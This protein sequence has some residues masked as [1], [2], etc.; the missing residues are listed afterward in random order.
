MSSFGSK[1]RRGEGGRIAF[2]C[3][4]CDEAHVIGVQGDSGIGCWLFNNDGDK[5]TFWPSVKVTGPSR[6]LSDDEAAR[7]MAGE[8]VNL[9]QMVCHSFVTDGRIQFLNDCT[10]A[11]AGQTVDLPDFDLE[12]E[13]C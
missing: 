4:G 10:H 9:P 3:P 6:F 5:P 2:W 13:V 8:I 11:L 1:L 12:E 7:V